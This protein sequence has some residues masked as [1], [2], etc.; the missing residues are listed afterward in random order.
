MNESK[1][2]V[3]ICSL[4]LLLMMI[5]TPAPAASDEGTVHS[6]AT[7]AKPRKKA[8]MS[9]EKLDALN[10][11]LF[12]AV[13]ENDR[14]SIMRLLGAGAH[15]DATDR[16]GMTPLMH[17]A[18]RGEPD[19]VRMLLA[20]GA[21]VNTMDIFGITALMQAA[22]AGHAAI[23]QILVAHG[24]NPNLQSTDEIPRL[25]TSGVN[26][27]M[28]ACMNSNLEVVKFL[29]ARNTDVDQRDAQG[30]T[31]L[32]YASQQGNAPIIDL[33][34]SKG[35]STELK[36]Q[37]GRTALTLATIYGRYKAVC[38]LVSAGA[39]V[40]TK[41]VHNMMPITYASALDKG[42]IYGY[43]KAAMARQTMCS[44]TAG[45]KLAP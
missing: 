38:M 35:A 8:K 12:E 2:R 34:L 13:V 27:L 31:A 45:F 15:V 25:R 42:D 10:L 11:A 39:D 26:A 16:A 6:K 21:A 24:A 4:C 36:D 28:G 5:S 1:C 7:V 23:V 40:R 18:L 33:L 20:K 17:A 22:W 3:L 30:Q 32:M 41:D 14:S 37:F 29:L 44:P 19:T 9:Q 43:L